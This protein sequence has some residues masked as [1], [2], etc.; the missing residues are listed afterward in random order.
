MNPDR[1]REILTK[2][3]NHIDKF[4]LMHE[5]FGNGNLKELQEGRDPWSRAPL[6]VYGAINY[7]V[8][9]NPRVLNNAEAREAWA[10]IEET[11]TEFS[12][13]RVFPWCDEKERLSDKD[14]RWKRGTDEAVALF[15]RALNRL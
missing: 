14:W 10:F 2:A 7:A 5:S 8:T 4:G 13:M 9:G 12:S 11:L 1:L 3:R 6:C 15:D